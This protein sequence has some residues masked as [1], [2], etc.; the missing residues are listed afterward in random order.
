MK[1]W[2]FSALI[3]LFFCLP[4]SVPAQT[5][6]AKKPLQLA[7]QEPS[8]EQRLKPVSQRVVYIP[9]APKKRAPSRRHP[10]G[11]TRTVD[12][13]LSKQ[14]IQ[15][16]VLSP[17]HIAHTVKAQPTL[18][19]HISHGTDLEAVFTL[20]E[21]GKDAVEPLIEKTLPMP[22][23]A[24]FHTVRLADFGKDL[25][26]GSIY[27]WS[28]S[29][30]KDSQFSAGDIVEKGWI[31][32][33][34]GNTLSENNRSPDDCVVRAKTYAERGIWYE[35]LESIMEAKAGSVCR[36]LSAKTRSDLLEQAGLTSLK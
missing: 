14:S 15:L 16:Y 21:T 27:E 18:Y 5:K 10:P 8:V 28:I 20:T 26:F 22:V 3:I 17:V 24:G 31:K 23:T 29:L 34:P 33:V 30:V 13:F 19:W 32:R 11:G 12:T 6:D 4:L 35:S 9:P 1:K 36:N 25:E 2:K 7:I